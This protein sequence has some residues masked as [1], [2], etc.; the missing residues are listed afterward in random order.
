MY[1]PEACTGITGEELLPGNLIG[2]IFGEEK[3]TAEGRTFE[4]CRPVEDLPPEKKK[5][6][7][8]THAMSYRIRE[9]T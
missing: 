5:Q 8:R 1:P 6:T 7:T 2:E 3:T 9:D 4:I